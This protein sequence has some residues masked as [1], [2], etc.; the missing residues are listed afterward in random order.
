LKSKLALAITLWGWLLFVTWLSYDYAVFQQG[1]IVHIFHPAYSYEIH[2]FYVLIFLVPFLY[3][4]LGYLVNEREVLLRR[5]RESEEKFRT[6]SLRDELTNL[7]NRRGFHFLAEQQLKIANRTGEKMLLLFADVD[8]LKS[9]NDNRGHQTGDGALM[10]TAAILRRHIRQA[11]LLARISGDEFVAL[12]GDASESLPEA[13]SSRIQESLLNRHGD[14]ADGKVSLSIGFA[15]Y[16]P[17]SPRSMEELV[18][19]A[20]ENMYRNKR[21]KKKQM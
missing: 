13:L 8:N 10:D 21:E 17:E 11:D 2:S 19:L 5:I 7:L 15:W 1:W 6:L 16:D 14:M 20:D 3:T 12:I 9:I 18:E 4:F